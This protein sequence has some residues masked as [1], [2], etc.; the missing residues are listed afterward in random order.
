MCM[1]V[2]ERERERGFEHVSA[3]THRDQK[4]ALDPLELEY[5]WL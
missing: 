3:D 5:R 2:C 4:R 1:C